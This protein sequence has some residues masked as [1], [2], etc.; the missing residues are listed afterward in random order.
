MTANL[1]RIVE[2]PARRAMLQLLPGPGMSPEQR[3][4]LQN[5]HRELARIE[6]HMR[7]LA[8]SSFSR[9]RPKMLGASK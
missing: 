4:A 6:A 2:T 7:G 8:Q 5:R 1:P 3:H 9:L